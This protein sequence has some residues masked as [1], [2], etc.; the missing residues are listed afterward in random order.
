M[1]ISAIKK[2]RPLISS[3]PGSFRKMVE[4][5]RDDRKI[6]ENAKIEHICIDGVTIIF[7]VITEDRI[8]HYYASGA[9]LSAHPYSKLRKSGLLKIQKRNDSMTDK[10]DFVRKSA[11][12]WD[13]LGKATPPRSHR[14]AA[15]T[16]YA[17]NLKKA[18]GISAPRIAL[19]G[20]RQNH[21]RL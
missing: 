17:M 12:I 14:A 7:R 16:V 18:A 5:F 11:A 19:L 13:D 20:N 10:D 15:A 1:A 2:W 3:G 21:Q 6:G 8:E 9:G 4:D